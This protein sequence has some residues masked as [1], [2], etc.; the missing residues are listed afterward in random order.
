MHKLVINIKGLDMYINRYFL[1]VTLSIFFN[2][3]VL[4]ALNN[5]SNNFIMLSSSNLTVGS[6][7]K[8]LLENMQIS[9]ISSGSNT[10]VNQTKLPVAKNIIKPIKANNVANQVENSTKVNREETISKDDNKSEKS[11]DKSADVGSNNMVSA[12]SNAEPLITNKAELLN[13]PPPISYPVSAI[14]DNA[15]GKVTLSAL[16]SEAGEITKINVVK[17]SGHNALD[18][19]AI[20]WFSKLKFRPALSGNNKISS[21]V[22]QVV[23]FSLEDAKKNET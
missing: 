15:Y 22:T 12:K 7:E 14:K 6:E 23:S 13:T 8:S 2:I 19:A 18:E 17:S 21:N 9:M 3:G 10:P 4:Y 20:K 1:P 16:I 5:N 11:I